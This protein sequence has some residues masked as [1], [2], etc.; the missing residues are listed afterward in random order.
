MS[1]IVDKATIT[2]FIKEAKANLRGRLDRTDSCEAMQDME[3]WA[4]VIAWLE[5][6]LP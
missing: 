5:G 3:S 2:A 1:T 6:K 4:S